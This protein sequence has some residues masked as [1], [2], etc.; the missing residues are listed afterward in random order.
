MRIGVCPT[1]SILFLSASILTGSNTVS[2]HVVNLPKFLSPS[3]L[4]KIC[5]L[6]NGVLKDE[7]ME[8]TENHAERRG[9]M[10]AVYGVDSENPVCDGIDYLQLDVKDVQNSIPPKLTFKAFKVILAGAPAAG[11]GTQCDVIKANFGLVHLS[12]GD[13]LRSAVE[14]KSDL[15]VKAKPYM[16][17]GHLVPDDLVI[18]LILSRLSDHDCETRGW[19]LDGFPRTK[20][21]AEALKN[22][23]ILPDVFLLLD[24]PEDILLERVTG[25]RTDPATGKIYHMKFSPPENDEVASRLVQRSDDTAEKI[26]IRY[27]EFQNH[28]NDI[29]STYIDRMVRIDGAS[30]PIEVSKSVILELDTA[31]LRKRQEMAG[32]LN[33]D[34]IIAMS[35]E[36][37]NLSSR[38]TIPIEELASA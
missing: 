27:K 19:L 14:Q 1:V 4:A 17:A 11:K 38:Y 24:V 36:I 18:E 5:H 35:K 26:T 7:E 34:M 6:P 23:G 9:L 8:G 16:D 21:Q 22:S 32:R 37:F 12:S 29:K 10:R 3:A 31:I 28:I 33:P 20:S 15:G 2:H 25:R 30:D 13:I